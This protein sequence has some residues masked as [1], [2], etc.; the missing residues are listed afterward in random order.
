MVVLVIVY[1]FF[2]AWENKKRDEAGIMEGYEHA[3]DDDFT[4]RTVRPVPHCDS[5]GAGVTNELLTEQAIQIC[6]LKGLDCNRFRHSV[7]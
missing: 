1:R 4:D 7:N 5:V 6:L 3:Y 2:C